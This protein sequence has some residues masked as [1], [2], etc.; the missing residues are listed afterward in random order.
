MTEIGWV[1]AG[2]R[3][4][5]VMEIGCTMGSIYLKVSG[6]NTSNRISSYQKMNYTL[7]LSHILISLALSQTPC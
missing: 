6:V 5:G 1:M 4:A 3:N 2:C 7:D